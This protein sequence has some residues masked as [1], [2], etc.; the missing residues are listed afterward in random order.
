MPD[1]TITEFDV[2][3]FVSPKVADSLVMGHS[4]F[5]IRMPYIKDVVHKVDFASLLSELNV[6]YIIDMWGNKHNP[7]DIDIILTNSMFKA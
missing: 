3:G 6:P 5:Q 7:N 4:S 2:E 1:I